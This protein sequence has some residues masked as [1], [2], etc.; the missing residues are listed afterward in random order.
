MWCGG[1][2]EAFMNPQKSH[3]AI[4]HFFAWWMEFKH[5]TI[6][7]SPGKS[8]TSPVHMAGRLPQVEALN[9]SRATY[10]HHYSQA[11]FP[12]IS[13]PVLFLWHGQWVYLPRMG[14]IKAC[15]P[16]AICLKSWFVCR[17]KQIY[18]KLSVNAQVAFCPLTF[19]FNYFSRKAFV[20]K[21][22]VCT[23]VAEGTIY[24]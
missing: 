14:N 21:V 9:L 3:F 4:I 8:S 6:F 5:E 22:W 23:S 19:L 16:F 24:S 11:P 15:P 17:W 10:C 7:S 18:F 12:L 13:S 1:V 2:E 20:T